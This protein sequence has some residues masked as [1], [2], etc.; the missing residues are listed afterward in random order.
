MT[1]PKS[2]ARVTGVLYLL[3]AVLGMFS[4]TV[5]DSVVVP[6]DAA[7]TA[8]SVLG[9]RWLFASSLLTWIGIVVVDIAVAVTFYVLL[10]PVSRTLSLLAAGIRLV[11]SAM[12]AAILPNL[13]DAF[14]LLTDAERG[15]GLDDRQVRTMALSALTTFSTGFLLAIV[16]FGVHLVVLGSLLYRSRYVPRALG[17]LVAAAGAGYIGDSLANL[18]VAAYGGPAS[19]FFLVPALVGELGLTGWLLVKGVRTAQPDRS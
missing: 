10:R 9:S 14:L 5:L 15:A 12:L 17:I 3:L 11:Y 6:G 1:S 2:L 8:G 4:A 7:A 18:F 16:F 13:Y 19:A